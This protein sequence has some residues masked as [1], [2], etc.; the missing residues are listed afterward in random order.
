VL[1]TQLGREPTLEEIAEEANLP[2]EQAKEVRAAA[3]A[4]MSLDQPVGEEEDA[5]LGDFVAGDGPP[6][7]EEVEVALRRDTVRKVLSSLPR[8]ERE[9]LMM[10][11]GL[12]NSK[13]ETLETIGRR[14]GLTRERVR[15]IE[16]ETLRRLASVH[17][18]ASLAR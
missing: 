18:M 12:G 3:R 16:L 9:V 14:L 15:Q 1:W 5:V 10:R 4:S 8:R 17:D 6:P 7:D 11:Y 2:L 13:P